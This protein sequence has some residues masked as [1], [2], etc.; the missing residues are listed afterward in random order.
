MIRPYQQPAVSEY[1]QPLMLFATGS[2]GGQNWALPGWWEG[3]WWSKRILGGKSLGCGVRDPGGALPGSVPDRIIRR[4]PRTTLAESLR[5]HMDSQ[6]PPWCGAG[7]C[8]G[9]V[10]PRAEAEGVSGNPPC[11]TMREWWLR[12]VHDAPLI[13]GTALELHYTD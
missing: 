5:E 7:L 11:A 13:Q 12:W 6:I 10:R 2:W 9:S 4:K 3:G 1:Q 8:R